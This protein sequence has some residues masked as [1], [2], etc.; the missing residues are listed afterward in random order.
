MLKKPVVLIIIVVGFLEELIY[1]VLYFI[2]GLRFWVL[3]RI[4]RR[5]LIVFCCV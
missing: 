1:V 2:G 3:L 4:S 5:L